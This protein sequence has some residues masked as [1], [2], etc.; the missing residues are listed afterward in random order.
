MEYKV[1]LD[2]LSNDSIIG[3][4]VPVLFNQFRK[5]LDRRNNPFE[6]SQSNLL[7]LFQDIYNNIVCISEPEQLKR[8]NKQKRNPLDT[9][10]FIACATNIY[11]IFG[12]LIKS[13]K[14]YMRCSEIKV[15]C[16]TSYKDKLVKLNVE[17]IKLQRC[18]IFDSIEIRRW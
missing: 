16:Y 3:N 13:Y 9:L 14:K 7:E 5:E 11:N 18:K 8:D 10:L 12:E 2:I 17:L 6:A 1:D 15:I 4:I